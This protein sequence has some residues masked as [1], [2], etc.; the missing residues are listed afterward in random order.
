MYLKNVQRN[1]CTWIQVRTHT[2]TRVSEVN[3][4]VGC[5]S[6]VN[7]PAFDA[8]LLNFTLTWTVSWVSISHVLHQPTPAAKLI[9]QNPFDRLLNRLLVHLHQR[10]R[11]W[12]SSVQRR[13]YGL[14]RRWSLLFQLQCSMFGIKRT[15]S[16]VGLSFI[17]Y[18]LLNQA[19][20]ARKKL[21][22]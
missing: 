5:I 1:T 11:V 13:R 14:F 19:S 15:E 4:I 10:K 6:N 9:F 12:I 22:Q 20:T 7:L 3:F 21:I 8:V 17:L 18:I 16:T 2:R